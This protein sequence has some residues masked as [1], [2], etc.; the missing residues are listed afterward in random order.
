MP[1]WRL[2]APFR[3]LSG[4]HPHSLAVALCAM[5]VSQL[6]DWSSRSSVQEQIELVSSTGSRLVAGKS[7]RLGDCS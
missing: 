2:G 5:T 4:E 3:W 1:E 7:T 6:R